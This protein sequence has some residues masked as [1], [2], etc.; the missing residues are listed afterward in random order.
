MTAAGDVPS[1]Q[2]APALCRFFVS[3]EYF[4]MRSPSRSI[5][6]ASAIVAAGGLL[7]AGLALKP[8]SAGVAGPKPNAVVSC[9]KSNPCQTYKNTI[10]AGLEG[11][12]VTATSGA[13]LEG[14]GGPYGIGVMGT[15][16][17]SGIGLEGTGGDYGVYG[18]GGDWGVYGWTEEAA[19]TGVDGRSIAGVGVVGSSGCSCD[20]VYGESDGGGFGVEALGAGGITARGLTSDGITA[21]AATGNGVVALRG[22]NLGDNGGDG[23]GADITGSYIGVIARNVVGQGYPFAAVDTNGQNLF[24]VD[25]SGNLFYHGSLF[26]FAK[27]RRG[28]V[29]T[30]FTPRSASPT[31]EDNGSAQLV[32]GVATVQ[33]DPAFAHS[34]DLRSA[35]QVML[36]PDGDTRG[37]YVASKSPTSFVVREVQGGQ[38]TLSFDYHIY[39]AGLGQAGERMTEMSPSQAAMSMPHA[40]Y[41]APK[42]RAAPVLKVRPSR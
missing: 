17:S 42:H 12:N 22:V 39:A 19:G 31:I 34:I 29:A 30:T 25:S 8:A 40:P 18:I 3:E 32:G 37:L 20:G 7:A 1:H 26:N 35:Y 15:G 6:A 2:C 36:T 27:T 21:T 33:L 24:F 10:G 11:I 38:G 14:L 4:N 41:V 9:S 16:G 28:Q 5:F 13:G 23:N